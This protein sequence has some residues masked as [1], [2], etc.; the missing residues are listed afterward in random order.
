MVIL[1]PDTYAEAHRAHLLG[2]ITAQAVTHPRQAD[3]AGAIP[4]ALP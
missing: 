1:L 4:R 3:R 2:Q